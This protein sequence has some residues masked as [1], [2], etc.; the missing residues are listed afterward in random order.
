MAATAMPVARYA[1]KVPCTTSCSANGV[2]IA[3]NG[4]TSTNRP[5][6][7]RN[8]RGAFIHALAIVTKSAEAAPLTATA[9]PAATCSFSGTRFHP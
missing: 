3:R 1:A 8:P 4:S 7:T 6:T 5:S 9:N 2:P